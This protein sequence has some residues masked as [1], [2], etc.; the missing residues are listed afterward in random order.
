MPSN[1][2]KRGAVWWARIQAGGSEHR[3]SL[4]TSDRK[5]AQKRLDQLKKEITAAVHFGESRLSWKAAVVRYLTEVGPNA[6]KPATLKRYTVSLG[7]VGPY[8]ESLYVDQIGRKTISGL[9]SARSKAGTS[10]ATINRDLT[11][12]SAVL[13][14]AVEWGVC[15]SNPARDYNRR[16]TRERRESIHPPAS[17]DVEAVVTRCPGMF[18]SMVRFLAHSGCRQEEAAGLTWGQVNLKAGTVTFLKTK[19]SRP[20]TIRLEPETVA[21]LTALPRFLGSDAV[22][23]HGEGSRYLNVAS[24]FREMVRSAQKSAQQAGTLFRPFRCH[25][26]RHGF[27]IRALQNGW[28]IYTLSKHLGHSSVKTTEIYL[29]YVPNGVGTKTGTPITVPSGLQPQETANSAS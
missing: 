9:V 23:W 6:V 14:A 11:A 8:L 28:D 10:N 12:V 15:E 17:A 18:A 20:R 2:Y 21:M 22:F 26:L 1:L 13:G 29:G 5:E 25:D 24:R 4:R 3:R 27:A 19:T 16:L 7:Q